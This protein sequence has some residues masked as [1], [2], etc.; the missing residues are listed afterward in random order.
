MQ[1]RVSKRG[2]K[3]RTCL[4]GCKKKK[5]VKIKT[6]VASSGSAKREAEK[7]MYDCP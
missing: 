2:G 7:K 1:I 4:I 6:I 3:G 5:R